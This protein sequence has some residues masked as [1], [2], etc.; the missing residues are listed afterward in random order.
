MNSEIQALNLTS[1]EASLLEALIKELYA[2]PGFSDVCVH[3][4]A[5]VIGLKGKAAGGVVSSLVKKG[6]VWVSE[7]EDDIPAII[8]LC[9]SYWYLH[10][11]WKKEIKNN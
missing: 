3:E 11:E 7:P 10:P 5:G 9:G 2:E 1:N 4:L 6:I 8:Y